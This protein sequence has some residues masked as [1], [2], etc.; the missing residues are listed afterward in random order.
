MAWRR[1]L[2]YWGPVAGYAALI[3]FLS[4]LSAPGLAAPF[5]RLPFGDKILHAGVYGG[6]ALL[7][8]RAFRHAAGAC[9]E[10]YALVLAVAVSVLYGMS[11]EFH[12][13]FVP[14][15]HPELW[16]LAA[17]AAGAVM[18]TWIWTRMTGT[19][20]TAAAPRLPNLGVTN[21]VG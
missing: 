6:M 16:D 1:V 17:D 10:R 21:R 13:F 12:Q 20:T 3:F 9:G 18:A 15:R 2:W 8:L 11:D 19:G 4:S 14:Q 5:L 7:A